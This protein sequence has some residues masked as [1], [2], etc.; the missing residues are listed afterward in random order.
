MLLWVDGAHDAPENMR[1]DACLLAAAE[2]DPAAEPVLRLFGFDPPGI[3]LG[4]GQDPAH[5]L[6]LARC[7]RDGIAWAVRPSGGRAIFHE[8]E[9]TYSF[10]APLAHPEGAGSAG[11]AYARLSI[12]IV[13]SLE[14]LGVPAALAPG[15]RHATR[16]PNTRG[17][18]RRAAAPCFASTARHEIVLEGR[19]LVGSAQRRTARA[20]LQQ[21]SVL[22]GE[23]H[24][25]LA[26]YVRAADDERQALRQS[27]ADSATHAGVVLGAAVPLER[28]AAALLAALPA[29][30]RRVDG[31]AFQLT[32]PWAGLYSRRSV[33]GTTTS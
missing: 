28:W 23:G 18:A 2:A 3:T 11:V 10:A 32:R 17:H 25:R 27:L 14:W 4:R 24:L 13:R 8:R 7:R 30:T 12:L 33:T 31:A 20:L 15:V 26:D 21:G 29:N 9:W 19:K 16:A 22:L 5:E 1:R 6:D